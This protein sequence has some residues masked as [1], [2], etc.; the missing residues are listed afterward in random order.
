M[1]SARTV[2]L[3]IRGQVCPSTLLTTLREVN[4]HQFELRAGAVQLQI[5][6]DNRTATVTVPQAAANMGLRVEVCQED[7]GYLI[8]IS[9]GGEE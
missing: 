9:K 8:R 3:D 6:T 7:G 4:R 5:R 2:E 1:E